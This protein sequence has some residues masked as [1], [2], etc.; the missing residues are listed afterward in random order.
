MTSR[1]AAGEPEVVYDRAQYP[2]TVEAL[3]RVVVLPINEKY[4]EEH[5]DFVADA[6]RRTAEFLSTR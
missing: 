1:S 6:V 4:T 5:V 3:R 2:G